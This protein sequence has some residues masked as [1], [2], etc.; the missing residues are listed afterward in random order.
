MKNPK[1]QVVAGPSVSS[2][3]RIREQCDLR[4]RFGAFNMLNRANFG[5]PGMVQR[6]ARFGVVNTT[7]PACQLQIGVKLRF[8]YEGKP[9]Q[10]FASM[11]RLFFL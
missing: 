8:Y 7:G 10:F 11:R 2:N 1:C 3:A 4:W 5:A 6:T 9:W